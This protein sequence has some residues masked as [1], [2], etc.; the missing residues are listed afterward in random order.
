MGPLEPMRRRGFLACCHAF[1]RLPVSGSKAADDD[2]DDDDDE[3]S[4]LMDHN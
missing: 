4:S 2:D 3:L 1:W